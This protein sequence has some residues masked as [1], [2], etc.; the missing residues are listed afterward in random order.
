VAVGATVVDG[1]VAVAAVVLVGTLAAA[2]STVDVVL[3]S[4]RVADEQPAS[5]QAPARATHAR[6]TAVRR[7]II[8]PAV[9]SRITSTPPGSQGPRRLYRLPRS[10]GSA[11]RELRSADT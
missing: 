10:R 7:L 8:P 9:E 4:A 1:A 6:T 5:A 3:E 2:A 11:M